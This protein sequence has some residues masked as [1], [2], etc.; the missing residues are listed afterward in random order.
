MRPPPAIRYELSTRHTFHLARID[1]IQRTHCQQLPM[2]IALEQQ[3]YHEQS[4]GATFHAGPDF[5]SSV[6][7]RARL[8]S[9]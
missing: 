1:E 9:V 7:L 6:R 3:S 5:Y 8:W 4:L 2:R